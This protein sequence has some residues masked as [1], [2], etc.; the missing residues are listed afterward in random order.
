[1]VG[2][3]PDSISI[4]NLIGVPLLVFVPTGI[5]S[6]IR[7]YILPLLVKTI[8]LSTVFVRITASVISSCVF[9]PFPPRFCV[10]NDVAGIRLTLPLSVRTT[11]HFSGGILATSFSSFVLGSSMSRSLVRRASPYLSLI[12]IISLIK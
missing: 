4:N 8:R 11:T 10:L 5:L 3:S 1:M 9:T 6:T 7:R 2:S 12:E